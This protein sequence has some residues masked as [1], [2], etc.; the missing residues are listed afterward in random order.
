MF[1]A[2][3]RDV[4]S[5][6]CFYVWSVAFNWNGHTWNGRE[7]KAHLVQGVDMIPT[8]ASLFIDVNLMVVWTNGDLSPGLVECVTGDGRPSENRNNVVNRCHCS[9]CLSVCFLKVLVQN[10]M[11]KEHAD[12]GQSTRVLSRF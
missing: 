9:I 4:T 3:S 5:L 11:R 12:S 2:Q 6:S 10:G 7:K 8:S 1:G